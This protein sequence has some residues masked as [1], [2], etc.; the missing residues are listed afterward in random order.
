[1]VV[2]VWSTLVYVVGYADGL[3]KGSRFWRIK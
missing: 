3:R 2:V 1:M